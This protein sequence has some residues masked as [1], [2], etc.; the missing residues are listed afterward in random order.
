MRERRR[1]LVVTSTAL[2]LS[3]LVWF[4]YPAVLPLVVEE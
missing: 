3:V 2:F 4:N 1:L